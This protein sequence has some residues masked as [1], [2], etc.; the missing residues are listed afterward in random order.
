MRLQQEGEVH[1][2]FILVYTQEPTIVIAF[3]HSPVAPH[4]I[5]LSLFLF[6]HSPG[7]MSLITGKI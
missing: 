7:K 3:L 6:I 2:C 1:I 4:A 5:R